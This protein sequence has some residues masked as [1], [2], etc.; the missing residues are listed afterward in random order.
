M[1]RLLMILLL[2]GVA[3]PSAA[4]RCGDTGVSLQVLGSGG[5][6]LVANRASRGALV[7]INGQAR[8]LVDAGGGAALR[9]ADSGA[10]MTDLDVVLFTRLH[11]SHTADLPALVESARHEP[12]TRPLPI[13]GPPGNRQTPS[14]IT[15]VRD[16]FDGGRGTFR[17]LGELISPLDKSSYKLE[18]HDVREP[19]P[20]LGTPRRAAA[21]AI[22]NIIQNDRLRIQALNNMQGTMPSTSFRIEAG[23]KAIVITTDAVSVDPGLRQ[24]VA[25]A[26]LLIISATGAMSGFTAIGQLARDTGVRQLVLSTRQPGPDSREQEVQAGLRKDYS[27][28]IHLADDL[29]CFQP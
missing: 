1:H 21:P 17:H 28:A 25:K 18:P 4:Q 6:A 23:G 29:S 27:G 12:R 8:V 2:L 3:T 26:D 20:K 15:F 10:R 5:P 16:L 9:F 24:L 19:P 11:A 7:W 14:T 13:F 22:M